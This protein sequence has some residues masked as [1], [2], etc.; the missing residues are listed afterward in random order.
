MTDYARVLIAGYGSIGRRHAANVRRL[1]PESEIG[2]MRFNGSKDELPDGFE[3]C[4]NI[5]EAIDFNPKVAILA[6]PATTH[7]EQVI[8]L[9]DK[10]DSMLIEKPIA[11]SV[12]EGKKIIQSLSLSR[13]RAIVGYNLRY[14][15]ALRCFKKLIEKKEYGRL[16]R[17][18][19]HV[20]Q[21]LS[22][23]R[24]GIDPIK[25]VSSQKS[26]GGG[27]F[28]E[29][30]HEIDYCLWIC[31]KPI[32]VRGR[33]A[34]Y[35]PYGDVE[36]CVD[37]WLD[38]RDGSHASIHMDMIDHSKRRVLRA[39]CEHST[40]EFDFMTQELQVNG[41]L[42]NS[43]ENGSPLSET[44]DHEIMDLMGY[45]HESPAASCQDA[46]AVLEV[47]EEAEITSL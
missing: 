47:I 26:L 44:Y 46:L 19:S 23:W 4:A 18:E 38:F 10:L 5:K 8:A 42:L 45:F 41:V 13:C 29:L 27:A 21:H 3:F 11:T 28:R 16:F 31:G 37:L 30:S 39:V 9:S 22:D 34:K 32:R 17:L 2:V 24:Q 35:L 15:P 1:L 14:T 7:L 36:D 25:T 33:Q 12:E 20:G 40:L 43:P 6:G